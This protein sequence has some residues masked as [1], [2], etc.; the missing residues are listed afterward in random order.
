MENGQKVIFAT[1][2]R[3]NSMNNEVIAID[4]A[5]VERIEKA[6]F[7]GI[8]ITNRAGLKICLDMDAARALGF[9]LK[10]L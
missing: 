3:T 4:H 1:A 7:N 2:N 8:E 5:T 10:S 6:T 9:V